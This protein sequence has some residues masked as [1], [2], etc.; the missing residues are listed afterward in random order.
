MES[1]GQ[2]DAAI[3]ALEAQRAVLGDDVVAIALAPLRERRAA[4]LASLEGDQRRLVTVLFA[5]LVGFTSM[6]E[7]L[8]AEDVRAILGRYFAEW[9]TAI[10]AHGGVVEKFIGDAVM[11]VFGLHGVREDDAERAI[12]AALAVRDGMAALNAELTPTYG[13]ELACRTGVDSGEVVVGG[14]GDRRGQ[15]WVVVG[16]IVNRASRVQSEAPRNGILITRDTYRLVRGVFGV[17]QQAPLTLKGVARPVVTYVIGSRRDRQFRI[18]T[19]GVEGV[20]TQTIGRDA[21]LACLQGLFESTVAGRV[22]HL[23]TVT[24]EAGVG[25]SRL[26]DE[27]TEWLELIPTTVR[28]FKGR[29]TPATRNQPN[30]LV[31]DIFAFRFEISDSDPADMVSE[32]LRSGFGEVLGPEDEPIRIGPWLGFATTDNASLPEPQQLRELAVGQLGRYLQ[33]LAAT[34]PIVILVEDLHWADDSTVELLPNVES[35]AGAPILVVTTARPELEDAHPCWGET[36]NRHTVVALQP[37]DRDTSTRLVS[38]ILQRAGDVPPAL[39]EQV[40]ATAEGNPFF[41]EELV[42]WFVEQGVINTSA[43]RWTVSEAQLTGVA[44]PPTLRGVLQARL[45]ALGHDER[46][47]LQRG[48]VIGREFWDEAVGAVAD[49]GGHTPEPA[50]VLQRLSRREVVFRRAR[51]TFSGMD[52]YVFKHALLRDVAYESVLRAQRRTYHQRAAAWLVTTT[53]AFNRTNEYAAAI[54]EHYDRAGDAGAAARWYLEAGRQAARLHANS[55]AARVLDRALALAPAE[56][57]DL[58]LEIVLE[59][60]ELHNRVADRVAQRDDLALL[61]RLVDASPNGHD[62]AVLLIR[63]C[64]YAFFES[65]FDE[66]ITLGEQAVLLCTGKPQGAANE[67]GLPR[68]L[69]S[70]PSDDLLGQDEAE[71]RTWLARGLIW[72]GRHAEARIA[73]EAAET[74]ARAAGRPALLGEIL[75]HRGVVA[76]DTGALEE[77]VEL[78]NSS[79]SVHESAGDTHGAMLATAQLGAVLFNLGSLEAARTTLEQALAYFE[80]VGYRYGITVAR[81]NLA[82]VDLD[83]G[84]L[85]RARQLLEQG[86]EASRAIG[87]REGEAIGLGNLGNLL[88]RCGQWSAAIDSLSRSLVV[89]VEVDYDPVIADAWLW[90]AFVEAELGHLDTAAGLATQAVERARAGAPLHE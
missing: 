11:A 41:I 43:P 69:L 82:T 90:M 48:A 25:K 64:R 51:S 21:E 40:V 19:R 66:V 7:K 88:A 81:S 83:Q 46:V 14:A 2:I 89:A 32:K 37:L 6:S 65:R 31:R 73:L 71:A 77:A 67:D 61:E 80:E 3:A 56:A 5:D 53:T 22:P 4:L 62:H 55:D 52:E 75:R 49:P 35:L 28:L 58:N 26:L 84:W 79:R 45:D 86:V 18:P 8:D 23:V 1:V 10:E 30:A 57:A 33:G 39:V 16:D 54:A 44:V 36:L 20:E 47:T 24:G 42:K 13:I 15:D 74:S 87:D 85:G 38:D 63:R 50:P 29:A 68:R 9:Q 60:D 72:V 76:N 34:S 70:W 78:L 59:R 27:L 17:E 12:D